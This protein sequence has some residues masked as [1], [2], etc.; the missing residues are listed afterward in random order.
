M[1]NEVFVITDAWCNHE[2]NLVID[3]PYFMLSSYLPTFLQN[4]FLGQFCTYQTYFWCGL[5]F[6]DKYLVLSSHK[7]TPNYTNFHIFILNFHST[8]LL[9]VQN[10]QGR[11]YWRLVNNQLW[12]M[13]RQAEV[14]Y[15]L[16]P[17]G[18]EAG[19]EKPVS[20]RLISWPRME[21]TTSR[22][23]GRR[24]KS[25][26]NLLFASTCRY[27]TSAGLNYTAAQAHIVKLILCN[28]C[29]FLYLFHC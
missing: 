16:V 2:N 10:I 25:W 24:F 21:P 20:R 5:L 15:L 13:W 27:Q 14:L 1:D 28:F 22:M 23:Q 11:M 12:R 18:T 3:F 19:H 9:A 26:S 4:I 7:M 8:L 6:L 17:Q 29:R